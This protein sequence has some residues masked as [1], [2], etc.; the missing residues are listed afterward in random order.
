MSGLNE[1]EGGSESKSGTITKNDR[2]HQV[3][4]TIRKSI[5]KEKMNWSQ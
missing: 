3:Q 5:V 1:E 4:K 2:T